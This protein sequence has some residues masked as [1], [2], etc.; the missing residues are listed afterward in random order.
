M[1]TQ[2]MSDV[3]SISNQLVRALTDWLDLKTMHAYTKDDGSPLPYLKVISYLHPVD[4]R[5]DPTFF[6]A[7]GWAITTV[8]RHR[9]PQPATIAIRIEQA[10]SASE[11]FLHTQ[12]AVSSALKAMDATNFTP[13]IE[14]IDQWTLK[15]KLTWRYA[16]GAKH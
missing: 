8:R 15:V 1:Y 3:A 5:T 11:E 2:T 16:I 14:Q 13:E 6:H 10:P 7:M 12:Q 4:L 9:T